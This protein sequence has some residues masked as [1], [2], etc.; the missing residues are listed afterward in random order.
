[1]AHIAQQHGDALPARR[2]FQTNLD[3]D[4]Q[5]DGE[6]HPNGAK[7]PAPEN[8]GQKDHQRRESQPTSHHAW[9]ENVTEH[10]IDDQISGQQ[11]Q[12]VVKPAENQYLKDRGIAASTE[13]MLGM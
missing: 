12:R 11:D 2:L 6:Q 1:M 13:P 5:R 9:F 4:G 3:D 8:Q 7:Q 10:Q